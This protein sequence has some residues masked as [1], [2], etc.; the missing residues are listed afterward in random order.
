MSEWDVSGLVKGNYRFRLFWTL[1]VTADISA[2]TPAKISIRPTTVKYQLPTI[3]RTFHYFKKN[4]NFP[5]DVKRLLK[6]LYHGIIFISIFYLSVSVWVLVNRNFD[7]GR[8]LVRMKLR[9]INVWTNNLYWKNWSS[10][11]TA[12]STKLILFI[13]R[14]Q[15]HTVGSRWN[16]RTQ[17]KKNPGSQNSESVLKWSRYLKVWEPLI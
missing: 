14:T 6:I 1:S 16:Y 7:F 12:F 17:W 4:W 13:S 5:T 9:T 10:A 11:Q 2:Y 8:S 15:R 3:L